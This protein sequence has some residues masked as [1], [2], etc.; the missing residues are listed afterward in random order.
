MLLEKK[1]FSSK[2]PQEGIRQLIL[3][4]FQNNHKFLNKDNSSSEHNLE[5]KLQPLQS[6]NSLNLDKCNQHNSHVP[7]NTGLFG[8]QIISLTMCSSFLPKRIVKLA[9]PQTHLYLC[10]L[11][12]TT[13]VQICL[14]CVSLCLPVIN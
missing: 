2:Q 6:H 3:S 12:T 8:C 7:S 9:V 4:L 11:G 14:S 10:P 1:W 13:W 5:V